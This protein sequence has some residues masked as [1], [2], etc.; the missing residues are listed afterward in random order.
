[1]V[2]LVNMNKL[3]K[4]AKKKGESFSI[5]KSGSAGIVMY[6]IDNYETLKKKKLKQSS[7]DQSKYICAQFSSGSEV[8]KGSPIYK[9]INSEEWSIAIQLT[10]EQAKKYK[11]TSGVKIKFLKDDVTTTANMEV[12]KGADKKRY[13]II[14]LSK[15]MV[16]YATDRF[17]DI[18]IIDQKTVG[19]KIPKTSLVTKQLYAIPKEYGA[20]GGEA[21]N[22]GFNRQ[23]RVEGELKNEF[24]Y[25]T[26]AYSDENNY[27]V[28]TTLFEKGDVLLSLNG[29]GNQFVIGNTQEFV[30][31]YSINNG[32]TVF[33]RVNILET[34]DEYYIVESGTVFG[35]A[36]YDRIVL[37]GSKV[38]ENQ[39][40]FQ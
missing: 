5:N 10:K 33:I 12:V 2:D 23:V 22:I 31:V 38:S 16:R 35:L 18:Q 7:F 30:G 25:P 3:Q 11:K 21:N 14:T 9:T 17:L 8:E 20:E 32:Y 1:V 4:L 15:Y 29:D 27:Y 26:I 13:G 36:Q 24:Y 37:D 40:V 28:S 19:L 39:I 6:R 34:L